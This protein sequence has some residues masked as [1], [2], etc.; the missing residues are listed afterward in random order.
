[1]AIYSPVRSAIRENHPPWQVLSTGS[2]TGTDRSEIEPYLGGHRATSRVLQQTQPHPRTSEE[3][4]FVRKRHSGEQDSDAALSM[5]STPDGI[6]FL[7]TGRLRFALQPRFQFGDFLRLQA[8]I[9]R[10][11]T[12]VHQHTN[13]MRL[14]L[15]QR[16]AVP[17]VLVATG[18]EFQR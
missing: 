4:R 3:G 12:E 17:S 15:I 6:E 18:A 8:S 14:Q 1:M 5:A 9:R 16:V 7:F 13:G 10:H 11:V 2:A